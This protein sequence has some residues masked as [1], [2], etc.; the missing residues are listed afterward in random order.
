MAL[1]DEIIS[2][3]NT[4]KA[5]K[6]VYRLHRYTAER[7]MAM[8]AKPKPRLKLPLLGRL[9]LAISPHVFAWGLVA[10]GLVWLYY[11]PITET[12]FRQYVSDSESW[13]ALAAAL[14]GAAAVLFS[15][16]VGRIIRSLTK[17]YAV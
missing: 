4:L 6:D 9:Y 14:F 3:I 17:A 12:Y 8:G 1:V 5:E 15:A 7:L 13:P 10:P 11:Q 2:L 16:V